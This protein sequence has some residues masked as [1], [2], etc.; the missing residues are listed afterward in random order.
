M[1]IKTS[2]VWN[3]QVRNFYCISYCSYTKER[4]SREREREDVVLRDMVN[5]VLAVLDS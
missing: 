1:Y 2:M 5:G 3:C 4:S